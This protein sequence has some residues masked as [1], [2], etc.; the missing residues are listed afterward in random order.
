[1]TIAHCRIA[2]VVSIL[3]LLFSFGRWPYGYYTLL[4][5]S[6][7]LTGVLLWYVYSENQRQN[8]SY[9][10]MGTAILFN[11]IILFPLGREIWSLVDI[12]VLPPLFISLVT[13]KKYFPLSG[14]HKQT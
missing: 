8:W 9:F 4:K 5:I 1:M 2:I 13:L 12:V 6:V 7:T 14:A 3:F 10:Y 11:P